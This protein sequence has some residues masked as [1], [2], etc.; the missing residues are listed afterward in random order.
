MIHPLE[1]AEGVQELA[2]SDSEVSRAVT[3]FAQRHNHQ[4]SAGSQ[5]IHHCVVKA[6]VKEEVAEEKIDWW[7]WWKSVGRSGHLMAHV[8]CTSPSVQMDGD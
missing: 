6:A 2:W 3:D 1:G 7:A 4:D 8:S 5:S